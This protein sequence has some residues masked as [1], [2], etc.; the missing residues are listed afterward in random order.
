MS[1]LLNGYWGADVVA[2]EPLID[3]A[4]R[5]SALADEI[6]DRAARVAWSCTR[7]DRCSANSGTP[8]RSSTKPVNGRFIWLTLVA[9]FGSP[10]AQS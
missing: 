1:L 6:A 3:L 9:V 5:L 4:L 7:C 8:P 2:R 10:D